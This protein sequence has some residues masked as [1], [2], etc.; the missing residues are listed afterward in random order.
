MNEQKLYKT[1]NLPIL[2]IYKKPKVTDWAPSKGGDKIQ[3][4]Q[5]TARCNR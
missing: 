4:T 2:Y 5:A 1:L 3:V